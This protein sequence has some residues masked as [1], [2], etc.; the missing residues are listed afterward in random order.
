MRGV[1]LGGGFMRDYMVYH[2]SQVLINQYT[3]PSFSLLM[4]Q[5]G[6]Q[7]VVLALQGK[8]DLIANK[9]KEL[10]HRRGQPEKITILGEKGK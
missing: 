9:G 5:T 3:A 8:V 7:Q 1:K 10:V 4:L 2:V 6:A